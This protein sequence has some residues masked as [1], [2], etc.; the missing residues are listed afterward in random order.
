MMELWLMP[1]AGWIHPSPLCI[2]KMTLEGAS[3]AP[4]V[5]RVRVN[6]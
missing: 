3:S 2:G 6:G 1:A 4:W 5:R